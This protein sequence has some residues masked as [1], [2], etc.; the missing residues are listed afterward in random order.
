VIDLRAI[1][2]ALGS[3]Q[4][5]CD[6]FKCSCPLPSHGKGRG[7]RDPSLSIGIGRSG[8]LIV[9]CFCGCDR[10]E[11]L[12]ELRR[13]GLYG[14]ES[15]TIVRLTPRPAHRD[16]QNSFAL[17][18]L[19]IWHGSID[20]VGTPVE[21]YLRGR[22]LDLEHDLAGHVIRWN[23]CRRAMVSL[24]RNIETDEPQAIA[25]TFINQEGRKLSRK[26][27]GP[28]GGA[29]IKLD[30]DDEVLAGLHVAEGVETAMTGRKFGLRPCWALGT[31][32]GI[33]RFPVLSGIE[34]L[35]ILAEHDEASADAVEAC[36]AR[37]HAA[38]R[39]VFINEPLV[40]SDLND[41]LRIT[42]RS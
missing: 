17:E 5:H 35:T 11:I 30:P 41:A 18:A 2:R 10:L 27:Y 42:S 9:C 19:D 4:P 13:R 34:C 12:A 39:Q 37:W 31:C 40:G 29:A 36:A 14:A 32:G 20:P 8:G 26:F 1:A 23:P 25:R 7:D 24:F 21:S 16:V 38:G 6:S 15:P 28:V 33:E 22:G 3:P